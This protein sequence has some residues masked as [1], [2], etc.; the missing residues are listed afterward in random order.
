MVSAIWMRHVS[1][2]RKTCEH[3]DMCVHGSPPHAESQTKPSAP[4]LEE[5]Q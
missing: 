4:E 3:I 5:D 2:A 1:M